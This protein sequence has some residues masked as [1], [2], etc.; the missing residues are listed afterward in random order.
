MSMPRVGSSR[1]ITF[2]FIAS[3]LA[4]TTFC[5]LP[6]ESVPVRVRTDGAL[7]PRSFFCFSA[8][9]SSALADTS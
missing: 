5:W 3:H 8:V 7:M 1:I 2:G 9:A 4:R 6:P